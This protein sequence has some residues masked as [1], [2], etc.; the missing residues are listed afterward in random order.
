[1]AAEGQPA[2]FLGE[3]LGKCYWLVDGGERGHDGGGGEGEEGAWRWEEVVC[4]QVGFV[5]GCG[6]EVGGE[7]GGEEGGL[8]GEREK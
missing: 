7:E 5:R 4:V 6:A 1:M 2:E 8:G 3:D